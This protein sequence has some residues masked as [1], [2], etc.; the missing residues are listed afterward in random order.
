MKR[1]KEEVKNNQDKLLDSETKISK[2]LT[3]LEYE[4]NDIVNNILV[5]KSLFELTKIEFNNITKKHAQYSL[6]FGVLLCWKFLYTLL[7]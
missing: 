1:L 4:K 6:T 3:D 7:L 5:L 2:L